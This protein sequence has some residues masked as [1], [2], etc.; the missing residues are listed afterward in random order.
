MDEKEKDLNE[1]ENNFEHDVKVFSITPEDEEVK[2][3]EVIVIPV[4]YYKH[5]V[6]CEFT[7]ELVNKLLNKFGEYS[8]ERGKVMEIITDMLKKEGPF[9]A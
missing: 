2:E 6:R 1:K 3:D 8:S 4:D 5:L 9:D 7:V